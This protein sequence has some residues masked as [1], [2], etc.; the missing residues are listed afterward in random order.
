L[1][2]AIKAGQKRVGIRYVN[3]SEE[4]AL[5][6]AEAIASDTTTERLA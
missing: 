3:F 2:D 5:Q 6:V 1:L 4:E